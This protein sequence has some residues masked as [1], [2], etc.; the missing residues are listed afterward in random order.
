MNRENVDEVVP[1]LYLSSVEEACWDSVRSSR[2]LFGNQQS[3]AA[4]E[5]FEALK[6][7]LSVKVQSEYSFLN[8]R[9]TEEIAVQLHSQVAAT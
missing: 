1:P 4:P 9:R 7:K 6:L 8:Q 3:T 5:F 2:V